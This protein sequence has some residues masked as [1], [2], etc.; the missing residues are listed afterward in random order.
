MDVDLEYEPPD[1]NDEVDEPLSKKRQRVAVVEMDAADR[2]SHP[3]R[4]KLSVQQ[5][6]D[7]LLSKY[8]QF[9]WNL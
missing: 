6:M 3:N 2:S 5:N 9:V 8:I 1:S 4:I 7:T